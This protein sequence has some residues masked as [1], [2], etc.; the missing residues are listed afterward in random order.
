MTWRVVV[1][2]SFP[3]SSWE[4]LNQVWV[5]FQE[6]KCLISSQVVFIILH[7]HLGNSAAEKNTANQIEDKLKNKE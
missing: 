5:G 6:S 2:Y 7:A 4:N 3:G 1:K